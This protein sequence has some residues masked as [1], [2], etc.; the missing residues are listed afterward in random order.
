MATPLPPIK[1][2]EDKYNNK[3]LRFL[4]KGDH[5]ELIFND[6]FEIP[7]DGTLGDRPYTV[8]T[9]IILDMK[10]ADKTKE[11]HIFVGSYGGSVHCLNMLIQ[12]I[13]KFNYVVGINLG[14][15]CSC[16][17]MLLAFCNE[18]YTTEYATFLYHS[19][20]SLMYGKVAE[21]KNTVAWQEKWWNI[22]LEQSNVK[23]ILTDEE[24]KLG[25][26]SEV[27]LT[28][29]DLIE[30]KIANDYKCYIVRPIPKAIDGEFFQ[31]GSEIYR[32][33]GNSFYRYTKDT[34][35]K[36]KQLRYG[37]V[38]QELSKDIKA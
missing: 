9:D 7:T 27:W 16:G 28:G 34:Q 22:L 33:C 29:K 10:D 1:N 6:C 31:V 14:Y 26:T 21:N 4:D 24:L 13:Q 18:I 17:F 38:I 30:R 5:Y 8:I 23:R 19:M 32:K 12:Q 15:A 36:K 37:E 3:A 35:T 20:S 25:E 2:Q 11:L